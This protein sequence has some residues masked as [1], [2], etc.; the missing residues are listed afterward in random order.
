MQ[1]TVILDRLHTS[2]IKHRKQILSDFIREL[3]V[4]F[5]MLDSVEAIMPEQNF[6]TLGT[7]SMEAVEFKLKLETHLNCSLRTTLLFDFPT[8]DILVNYLLD[9]VLQIDLGDN[10]QESL[11]TKGNSR[12]GSS[13]ENPVEPIVI[14]AME[15]MFSGA[16]TADALWSKSLEEACADF[17]ESS[18]NAVFNFGRIADV[19]VSEDINL[20]GISES[21]FFAMDRQ[22]QLLYK[23][24]ANTLVKYNIAYED[25]V[26]SKTG[27]FIGAGSLNEFDGSTHADKGFYISLANR[28]SYQL[29]LKGPSEVINALCTSIY[30]ALHRAVQSIQCDECEQAIVGAVN[31]IC[32]KQFSRQAEL[33]LYNSLLSKDNKTR[34][35]SAQANGFV[36]SEG[37]GVVLMKTLSKAQRDKNKILAI[38]KGTSVCHGGRG[39]SIEAPNAQG[40]RDSIRAA[41]KKANIDT[42]T[43]DYIEAHGIGNPLAD[44]IELG[45]INDAYQS[46]TSN[47]TKTWHVSTVKPTVGHP[48]I[49]SGIA[50]LIKAIKAF[51]HNTIPGIAGLDIVNTDLAANHSLILQSGAEAWPSIDRPR[52]VALNSYAI[53]GVSAHVILEEY[54][55]MGVGN[56]TYK[57]PHFYEHSQTKIERESNPQLDKYDFQE[58][59]F[60]LYFEIF[61]SD[62]KQVD[63][64]L[65]PVHYGFDSIKVV[66]FIRRIN[67]H[68]GLDIKLGQILGADNFK[69]ILEIIGKEVRS[70]SQVTIRDDS[71]TESDDTDKRYPLSEVQK[72]LW[73][74]NETI[75]QCS[76]FNVPIVFRSKYAL[77]HVFIQNA[78]KLVLA[79]HPALRVGFVQDKENEVLTQFV[80]SIPE[81]YVFSEKTVESNTEEYLVSILRKPFRLE[82]DSLVRLFLIY[83][84]I[85]AETIVCF[86]IHHIVIDGISGVQFVRSFWD[87][88]YKLCTGEPVI[89]ARPDVNFFNFIAWEQDYLKS[90]RAANDLLWWKNQLS[91]LPATINLPYDE[92]IR[93]GELKGVGCEKLVLENE[94]LN[95]IKQ[96]AKDLNVNV[97]V[98]LLTIFAIVIHKL[99]HDE[100][101]AVTTPIEGRPLQKYEN[102]IGCYINLLITR[103]NVTPDKIFTTLLQEVKESFIH[104]LDHAHY[105][106]S[107]LVSA[108]NLNVSQFQQNPLPVCYTYQNIFDGLLSNNTVLGNVEPVYDLYQE[109]ED[110]YTL[111]VYDFRSAMQINLKYKKALF[112]Q[113]TA[114]RHLVYFSNLLSTVIKDSS[115]KIKDYEIILG[116]ERFQLLDKFNSTRT[117]YPKDTCI[118]ELFIMQATASPNAIAV[119]FGNEQISYKNLLDQSK[120]LARVLKQKGVRPDSLV[121]IC[122]PRSIDMIVGVLAILM[123]GGAY[124]PIEIGYPDD[125]IAEM[126]DDS[127]A[128]VLLTHTILIDRLSLLNRDCAAVTVDGQWQEFETLTESE[129]NVSANNLAYVIYTSGSTGKPKGVMIEHRSV[130]NH[131]SA[132]I[133]AYE[134]SKDD[135]VLQ[136]STISF[137]IFVEEVF[138][139]LLVGATLVLMEDGKF[140]DINYIKE[141]IVQHQVTVM[142]L[143]TGYWN[144]LTEQDLSD[145]RLRLVVIGGEKVEVMH[146]KKWSDRN[147]NIQIINTYG[148]TETTVISTLYK[149]QPND[150]TLN[151]IPIGHPIDNTL[152]YILDTNH[153]LVPIGV[154]GTLYIGGEGLARG[155]LNRPELTVEK[156]ISNP[157]K[158]GGMIYNT[159]D[160]ARWLENGWVE[161]LGRT[162]QQ[163]KIRGYRVEL[164]EVE[165]M[166]LTYPD[167]QTAVVIS[168]SSKGSKQL[169]A[170]Y[171]TKNT[172]PITSH[173]LRAFFT[174]RM[175]NY[176]IP[177]SFFFMNEIPLTPNGKIDRHALGEMKFDHATFQEYVAPATKTEIALAAIWNSILEMSQISVQDNFFDIGGHSLLAI[178]LAN[179]INNSLQTHI[180]VLNINKYP[181]ISELSKFIDRHAKM[182]APTPYIVIFHEGDKN[183]LVEE[184]I[185]TFIIPGMPGLAD[186]YYELAS[187]IHNGNAVY[188][189]QMKGYAGDSP[190][191]SIEEMAAHNI[192][193]I[194][195]ILKTGKINLYAHSYGGTVVYEM[196]RQLKGTEI[197]IDEV[198]LMDSSLL[199]VIREMDKS[200]IRMFAHAL[201]VRRDKIQEKY[202]NMI[203]HILSKSNNQWKDYLIEMMSEA[204]VDKSFFNCLWEL[205]T[206]SLKVQYQHNDKLDNTVRLVVAK[207]NIGWFNDQCW[208]PY[209][210]DVQVYYSPGDHLSMIREP[211]CLSWLK[212]IKRA[213]AK[214]SNELLPMRD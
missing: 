26:L 148:P 187:H 205:V 131:N 41:V 125:R 73:Y 109:T 163:V 79:E 127:A 22:Q 106:F 91:G 43:V 119:V 70:K 174:E 21:D 162:D 132:V 111:E 144:T 170:Y 139:T 145:T 185:P 28:I 38:V 56:S 87:K 135:N 10:D 194:H 173:Q 211:H 128:Q 113:S 1:T 177:S 124:V 159:G 103:I 191:E 62:L 96:K 37:A 160:S 39:Y 81:S 90:E 49:A 3:L 133:K 72:G 5:L 157:F 31:V 60:D 18:N 136:F 105:P 206:T 212:E 151:T 74:I 33:N 155:Y 200:A 192:L 108:L 83:N 89:Q 202:L 36:R 196:I 58:P 143:P 169:E 17:S 101:I 198:V 181:T 186:G 210:K 161:Y 34:S 92:S 8:L 167:I 154:T 71:S 121:A 201:L 27:V 122:V 140:M 7:T 57:Q 166:L 25:L 97:S 176:M 77:N 178:Q 209:Y 80:K 75:P 85:D 110:P 141:T 146:Y 168:K 164:G 9:D 208:S 20:L 138:P 64:S 98:F 183:K 68:F 24:I 4:D 123:A 175:P 78:L 100:D 23:L 67:Q 46:L 30:S 12:E 88:Y 6:A 50:S 66:Q 35:F 107:K 63:L 47:K 149:L 142:N 13:I 2:S 42:E 190:A 195:H 104:G 61:S 48:E 156:F 207:D 51:E 180:S 15:G 76:A 118:H 14:V 82:S 45:A 99:T 189:L 115:G 214:Q 32:P 147:K 204:G 19:N 184:S 134:L 150:Q 182:Q 158:P 95:A 16:A 112:S 116:G 197:T 40:I 199:P 203:E 153:N 84:P 129:V 52:R 188:G 114:Q 152:L 171:T 65:S 102:S 44:A 130:I 193:Q 117:C 55:P 126:L 69:S 59:L 179:K 11:Q 53:G 54:I 29:N 93:D 86:V 120:R 94:V 172:V 213:N 137:D 165:N